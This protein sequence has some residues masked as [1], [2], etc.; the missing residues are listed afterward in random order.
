MRQRLFLL[1]VLFVADRL[2][3]NV[4][5]FSLP[6]ALAGRWGNFFIHPVLNEDIS[7]SI[8][9]PNSVYSPF[10]IA[11]VLVITFLVSQAVREYREGNSHFFWWGLVVAGAVS[12]MLDRIQLGGVLDYID[13]RIWPV[14]NVSDAYISL[15][16]I[17]ILL[18]SLSRHKRQRPPKEALQ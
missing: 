9:I 2:L 15:G 12:N 8:P 6:H 14:F 7:F 1:G 5:W 4:I 3:K 18:H 11:L 16:I 10:M 13:L 17:M